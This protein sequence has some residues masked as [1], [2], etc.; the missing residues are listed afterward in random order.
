[1][2]SKTRLDLVARRLVALGILTMT[3]CV[4]PAKTTYYEAVDK[5]W[6]AAST[7]GNLTRCPSMNYG[8]INLG[9][10]RILLESSYHAGTGRIAVYVYDHENQLNFQTLNLRLTSL[11]DPHVQSSIPL[12]FYTICGEQD[13]GHCPK[14]STAPKTLNGPESAS[15]IVHENI[16]GVANV[17]PE[18]VGGFLVEFPDA[19]NGLSSIDAKPQ[20]F[21]LRTKVLVQGTFGCG[22]Y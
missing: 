13:V 4:W 20:K 9:K 22:Y 7:D 10:T 11:T 16:V 2:S 12:I 18:L 1:M 17:P 14:A 21:E 3:A 19:V 8:Q 5:P 15:M 6:R